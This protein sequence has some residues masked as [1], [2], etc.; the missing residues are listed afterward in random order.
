[1]LL[2]SSLMSEVALEIPLGLFPYVL[3]DTYFEGGK[4]VRAQTSLI[5]LILP[6]ERKSFH[7]QA[8]RFYF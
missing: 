2:F 8:G 5:T 1:M 4:C 7:L 3:N 6:V